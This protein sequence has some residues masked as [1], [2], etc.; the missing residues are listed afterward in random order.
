MKI[1]YITAYNPVE[2]QSYSET[3]YYITQAFKSAGVSLEFI[4]NLEK[5]FLSFY[6]LKRE[7]YNVVYSENY[8]IER[9]PEIAKS[10]ARQI[11]KRLEELGGIDA[12]FTTNPIN[13]AYLVSHKPIVFWTDSVFAGII[14]IDPQFANLSF[15]SIKKGNAIEQTALTNCK[16]AVYSSGWGAKTA[17]INYNINPDKIR[18]VPFGASVRN[19]LRFEDVKEAVFNRS[20]DTC[21]LLFAGDDWERDGG[22]QALKIT[23][24]L[25]GSGLDAELHIAGDFPELKKAPDYVFVHG[26]LS[27]RNKA[28]EEHLERLFLDSHFLLNLS[29]VDYSGKICLEANAYGLPAIALGV[30]GVPSIITDGLNGKLFP[31]EAGI[32]EV[33]AYIAD[34]ISSEISYRELCLGA[35]NEYY[36]RLNWKTAAGKVMEY[37]EKIL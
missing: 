30:G 14:N 8:S 22:K 9:E 37:M 15:E 3:D 27:R 23:E 20:K 21:R 32:D 1:A 7:L 31:V 10:Y 6:K 36:T 35:F 17:L 26:R 24:R 4:G 12:I 19:P 2:M 33:T 29:E 28:A 18:V 25:I 5:N 16:L 11:H 13:T 34:K